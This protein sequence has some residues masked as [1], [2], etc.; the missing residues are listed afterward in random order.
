MVIQLTAQGVSDAWDEIAP[1][2]E[3]APPPDN[4]K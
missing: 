4:R 1:A 2:I 3:I